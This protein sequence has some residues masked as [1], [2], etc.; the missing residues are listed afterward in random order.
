MSPCGSRL[1][2]NPSLSFISSLVL[3]YYSPVSFPSPSVTPILMHPISGSVAQEPILGQVGVSNSLESFLGDVI[4]DVNH[5][6]NLMCVPDELCFYHLSSN[7]HQ[8]QL[9]NYLK[10]WE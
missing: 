1:Q 2:L 7:K 5:S 4:K 8:R 3:P 6:D 9:S 10:T